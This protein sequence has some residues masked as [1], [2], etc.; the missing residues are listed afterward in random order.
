LSKKQEIG[1]KK[2]I[3]EESQTYE[4]NQFDNQIETTF[5][6]KKK[7]NKFTLI[8]KKAKC[9]YQKTI[10]KRQL[11]EEDKICPRCKGE[12]KIKKI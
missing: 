3:L 7:L 11:L 5:E 2:V 4:E 10:L 6:K 12:M 9:K 1:K 8:C